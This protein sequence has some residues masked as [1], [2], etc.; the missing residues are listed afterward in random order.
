MLKRAI[1]SMGPL[2]YIESSTATTGGLHTAE[3]DALEV[4]AGARLCSRDAAFAQTMV[5]MH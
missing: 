5:P 4:F 3:Q 2:L 1:S